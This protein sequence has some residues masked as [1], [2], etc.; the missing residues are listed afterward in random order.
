MDMQSFS[1]QG[2]VLIAERDASGNAKA[3]R[4]AGDAPTFDLSL[5]VDKDQQRESQSGR[6]LLASEII[7]ANNS[8]LSL[9]LNHFTAANLGLALYSTPVT[10]AASTVADET[11]P[12]DL[13]DGDIVALAQQNISVLVI[14]D[15]VPATL[16]EDT[17]YKIHSAEHGT[18]EMLDIASFTQPLEADYDY[19]GGINLAMFAQPAPERWVRLNG[20]NTAEQDKPVL[21]DL[22]RVQFDPVETMTLINEAHG[23]LPLSGSVLYDST[24][25]GDTTLG[26]FG[27]VMDLSQAS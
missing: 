13:V 21:V 2:E 1:F 22:Y 12:D 24:K 4:R 25:D 6:R 9:V 14:A 26:Q 8:N 17:H 27:R 7:T 23:N 20:I 15:Q 11:L 16:V 10:I 19:A 18:V 3:F 5:T